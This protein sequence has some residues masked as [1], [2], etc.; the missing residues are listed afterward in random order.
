[1]LSVYTDHDCHV[2]KLYK[3]YTMVLSPGSRPGGPYTYTYTDTAIPFDKD[4]SAQA[5]DTGTSTWSNCVNGHGPPYTPIPP[6]TGPGGPCDYDFDPKTVDGSGHLTVT[7]NHT[8]TGDRYSI[9]IGGNIV[10]TVDGNNSTVS[11]SVTA[12]IYKGVYPV[13]IA[14]LRASDGN[15]D[16]C[17]ADGSTDLTVSTDRVSGRNPCDV[18]DPT[19]PTK[20]LCPTAFGNIPTDITGF[21]GTIVS[22]AIGIAGG[23]ALILLVFG[24]IRVLVSRGDPERLAGGRDVIIAAIAGLLFLI[25]SVLILRSLGLITGIV[26]P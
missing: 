5:L 16:M 2:D 4:F 20:R 1:M 23:L 21:A 25:F 3:T 6:P 12:P 24:S 13:T 18:P 11:T 7:I 26:L 9:Y 8:S 10:K 17:T 15:T 14:H 22:I 19:D